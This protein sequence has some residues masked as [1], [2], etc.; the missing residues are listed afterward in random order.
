MD[1]SLVALLIRV[2]V[3]LGVVLAVMAGAAAVL[4]RSG[5]TGTALS[6]R[7]GSRR[8]PPGQIIPR[9][10]PRRGALLTVGRRAGPA[11]GLI[12]LTWLLVPAAPARAVTTG[13]STT[14]TTS[15]VRKAAATAPAPAPA[16]TIAPAAA[17]GA[18][19]K[20]SVSLDLGGVGG[21]PSQSL[22]I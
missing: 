4:R 16:A 17:A 21:K 9:H 11:C 7:R 15:A 20:A 10:G 3:S 22:M 5:V 13:S 2:V 12:V 6:G 19:T 1:T 18:D 14:T 8:T